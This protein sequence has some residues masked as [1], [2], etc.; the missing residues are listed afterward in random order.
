MYE[1]LNGKVHV[2]GMVLGQFTQLVIFV[3]FVLWHYHGWCVI[4]R[5]VSLNLLL[6][7]DGTQHWKFRKCF[8]FSNGWFQGFMVVSRVYSQVIRR[9]W[10]LVSLSDQKRCSDGNWGIRRNRGRWQIPHSLL[11]HGPLRFH[12]LQMVQAWVVQTATCCF[13]EIPKN[14][15]VPSKSQKSNYSNQFSSQQL[16][17]GYLNFQGSFPHVCL[18]EKLLLF[19]FLL[20]SADIWFGRNAAQKTQVSLN[21][22]TPQE[23]CLLQYIQYRS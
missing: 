15:R 1:H 21:G 11:N 5:V 17:C 2:F 20:F 3:L 22:W 7:P 14:E 19:D 23:F 10:F 12:C 18:K 8:S 4:L 16:F 9:L 6:H 13:Q